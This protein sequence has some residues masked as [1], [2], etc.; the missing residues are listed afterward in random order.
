MN[1]DFTLSVYRKLLQAILQSGFTVCT[2]EKWSRGE[3][4]GKFVILRHDVDAKPANSLETAKIEAELGIAASYYFRVVPQSNHPEIIKEIVALGHEIGYHYEDLTLFDGDTLKAIEHFKNQLDYFRQFYPVKTICMHGSPT[5]K[6]DNRKIW[7]S[8]DYK[9][10]GITGEPY[11]DFLN[12]DNVIY[13]TDTARMWDGAKYNIRDKKIDNTNTTGFSESGLKTS[14]Y[15]VHSTFDLVN[16]F[17]N[18]N[19]NY[20]I[21]ITTHPQRW[22][23]NFFSWTKELISQSVKNQIKRMIILLKY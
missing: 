7:D 16:W 4:K 13:F 3:V 11:F 23:N 17:V 20:G 9:S 1:T 8:Y 2:F 19:T 22:T 6:I 18:C 12:Q 5:S 10:F 14:H 15:K 21:M